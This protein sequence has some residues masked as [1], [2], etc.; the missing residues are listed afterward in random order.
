MV[1]IPRNPVNQ[2][3]LHRH[4]EASGVAEG[5][6]IV[7]LNAEGKV[8]KVAAS[9]QV[10]YGILFQRVKGAIPG[11][12]Q[13][14]EAPGEIG[15]SDAR[16]GDPVLIYQDGGTFETDNYDLVGAGISAGSLLYARINVPADNGKLTDDTSDVAVDALGNPIAVAIAIDSLTADQ[17]SAGERLFIKSLI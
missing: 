11:F 8:G 3:P 2:N 12:P 1:L 15:A 4:D 9:G 14:Y 7:A 16:L 17:A 5:G 6:S 13:N 10:P